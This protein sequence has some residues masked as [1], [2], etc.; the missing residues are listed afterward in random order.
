M[1]VFTAS[2][3]PLSGESQVGPT[4][5]VGLTR[6]PSLSVAPLPVVGA[7]PAVLVGSFLGGAFLVVSC[8]GDGFLLAAAL[9]GAFLVAAFFGA[10]VRFDAVS[11]RRNEAL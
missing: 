7:G 10:I 2:G 1:A 8:A 3:R 5:L 11:L 4:E 6:A 9:A